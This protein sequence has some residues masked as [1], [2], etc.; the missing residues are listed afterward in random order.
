MPRDR[1]RFVWMAALVGVAAC[2]GDQ[3]TGPRM[4]PCGAGAGVVL[5]L[6]VGADTSIDPA[7]DSGC[8]PF[9]ANAGADTVEYLLVA[10]SAASTSGRLSPFQLRS[11]Q[12]TG[13]AVALGG[14]APV[15]GRRSWGAMAARFDA[16]R[17]RLARE[18]GYGRLARVSP[19]ARAILAAPAGPPTVGSLRGF[20]VCAK[21]DCSTL[22]LVTG[23]AVMVSPHIAI[24]VDTQ[25]PAGGLDST[26][27]DS[28][29]MLLDTRLYPIDTVAFGGVSDIDGNGV[30]AVLM[31]GVVNALVTKAQCHNAGYIAGFFFG[32]DLDPSYATQYSDGE[33]YYSIVP[34]PDS[35]L[36]CAHSASQVE[37]LAPVT[38]AHEFQHM[39]SFVQHVLVRGGPA[40]EGWL[41]EGMSKYAEELAGRS[42][43]PADQT[44]FTQY[45]LDDL[46][47]GYR[48]LAATGD[49][50]L[51]VPLDTGG[52]PEIGA[53]WLFVRYLVDQY[54]DSL[55]LRLHETTLT[56]AANV[57]AR[58]GLPFATSV[59]RWALANWV[60]DLPGFATPSELTYRS[61]RFRTTYASLNAQD[62]ADFPEPFPLVP[63][64]SA[65]AAVDVS[66]VLRSG[67]G[68]YA[69]AL[70][71][72]GAAGFT[73]A[74]TADGAT[75]LPAS[76]VPRLVVLRVR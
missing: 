71:P 38:F 42:F 2:G 18:R 5:T 3:S 11:G 10:Q 53:S 14:G 36:S 16:F 37:R 32:G 24:Y 54:G 65:A 27:L 69:R 56:G 40:E 46:Y 70:Q 20:R 13:A 29:G 57:A 34:D 76:V 7:A 23:R 45:V 64:V 9:A 21:L 17:S 44:T 63:M 75:L 1:A 60:S 6:S 68:I 22:Q 62:P 19:P 47:D 31:T 72:P 49:A 12:S 33:V 74:F 41:D 51:L 15:G 58:T 61:W 25:A 66:G 30:V 59:A 43:L 28:L 48:Y 4:S 52:L 50:S 39:I 73:L 55:P 26:A 8:V 35:T 67:S